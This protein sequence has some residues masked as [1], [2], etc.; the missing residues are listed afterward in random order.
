M[1][2]EEIIK[3]A[4]EWLLKNEWDMDEVYVSM[5]IGN[6]IVL[7]DAAEVLAEFA[8][9]WQ[10]DNGIHKDNFEILI[11]RNNYLEFR[12]KQFLEKERNLFGRELR[13]KYF[14]ECT[15][16]VGGILK[17]DLAPH[18]LFEWFKRNVLEDDLDSLTKK[19]F[20]SPDS[21]GYK[22]LEDSEKF[23]AELYSR[24]KDEEE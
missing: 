24:L 23:K 13:K 5:D 20:I 11:D 8:E 12:I 14:D 9:E 6:G 3:A 17:V 19:V 15:L 2:K 18:D 4:R 1:S 7:R 22:I 10:R 16:K 21:K